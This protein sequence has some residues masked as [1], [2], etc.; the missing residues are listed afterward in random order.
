MTF[1]NP[2]VLLGL[3]AAAIPVIL[4]LLNRRKL[5]TVEFSS[6]RFLKEL[7]HSSLR[8]L[9]IRQWLLLLLRTLLI[10]ALVLSFARPVIHGNLA[11]I[12]GSRANTSM[13][14]VVD[15]SPSMT[16]RTERG[17]VFDRVREAAGR[18]L[19]LAR[20][21]DR[22]AV[23]PLSTLAAESPLPAFVEP[24]AARLSL[25]RL[26]PT[27]VARRFRESVPILR[28]LVHASRDANREVYIFTDAQATQYAG[29]PAPGDSAGAFESNVRFFLVRPDPTSAINAGA[30]AVRMESR[31]IARNRPAR[32]LVTLQNFSNNPIRQESISLY[33]DRARVAQQ[34]V[35]LPPG[36]NSVVALS[37]VPKRTGIL[38]GYAAIDDDALEADNTLWFVLDVPE[39]YDVVVTGPGAGDARYPEVALT[40]GGDS[41][42]AGRVVVHHVSRE[43]LP[44]TDLSQASVLLLN[45]LDALAP[46]EGAAAVNL[47]RRGGSVLLFPGPSLDARSY[48]DC[49]WKP[50][51]LPEMR[52]EPPPEPSSGT[53]ESFV[54]FSS[55]DRAHPLFA[56]MFDEQ[57]KGR[58]A[59]IESPKIRRSAGL[60]PG[61][62]GIS[63]ITLSNGEAFLAEF[64]IGSG[65]VLAFGVDPGTAWSDF[66]LKGIF[67]PLLHRAV[68]Y[69]SAPAG[70][71]STATVG[72]PLR[73]AL[74][75]GGTES[76][77][78][79]SIVS[80]S[81]LEERVTPKIRTGSGTV[82]FLSSPTVETGVYILREGTANE[83]HILAA[84]AVSLPPW[85]GD[86][87][88]LRDE[89]LPSFWASLGLR[90]EAGK[91]LSTEGDLEKEVQDTR[92]G[93]ELWRYF[94]ALAILC[95]LGEM[96]VG[97]VR[98]SE[99]GYR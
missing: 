51:G 20:E 57:R 69:C 72:S 12:F 53:A 21:G 6:L 8:R 90:P 28:A 43:Q 60:R 86:L 95:A 65:K 27:R 48:N 19:Q 73:F 9:K 85:E 55:V 30:T 42:I 46:A 66:P 75:G 94:L 54:S 68:A 31:F 98:R 18:V 99:E 97:H 89:N 41:L 40:L 23:L 50:L 84:R 67:A 25:R 83:S 32:A 33:L 70:E 76:S 64:Q 88:I 93:L 77:Q 49:F 45:G 17:M 91:A 2:L 11:G 26:E 79:C 61:G 22:V 92:Y 13:V 78:I 10:A 71:D 58:P 59:S 44:V 35:D 34:S 87:N 1:L 3:A 5:R 7:Q 29:A 74:R 39:A 14:F 82:E 63:I 47:I 81:G 15:D 16:V 62:R 80:P 38:T 37:L 52:P 96:A 4:H 36:E 56:G 24:S